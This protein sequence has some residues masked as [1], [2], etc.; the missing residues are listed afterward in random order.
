MSRQNPLLK[1]A[2]LLIALTGRRNVDSE[3]GLNLYQRPTAVRRRG[4]RELGARSIMLNYISPPLGR[5]SMTDLTRAEVG[6]QR[7]ATNSRPTR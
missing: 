1:H 7:S 6:N 5:R 3:V 4:S 2:P